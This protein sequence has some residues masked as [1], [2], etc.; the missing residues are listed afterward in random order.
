MLSVTDRLHALNWELLKRKAACY[1]Q[2]TRVRVR[3]KIT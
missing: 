1:L 3:V 2:N